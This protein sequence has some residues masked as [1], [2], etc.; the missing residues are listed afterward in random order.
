[1]MIS[2]GLTALV[3]ATIEHRRQRRALLA[4][5]GTVPLSLAGVVAALVAVLGVTG[6]VLVLLRQ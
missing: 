6:L 2:I 1:M 5:Y 4:Q 3:L